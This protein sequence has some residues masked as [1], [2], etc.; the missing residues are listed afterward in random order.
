MTMDHA[1]GRLIVWFS[2][3]VGLLFELMPVPDIVLPFRPDWLLLILIYW[4]MA[5]PHRY[6]I[7]TAF[8]MGTLLDVLLGAHLGIRSLAYSLAI[9]LI[10][11]NFQRLRTYSFLQQTVL[12]GIV[13]CIYHLIVFWLQFLLEHATFSAELL[14][15]TVSSMILWRWVFW[16]L[17]RIR[18]RYKVR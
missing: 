9:Y 5:L 4:S 11:L 6:N 15:P 17:R 7:L 18:R 14:W 3:L 12:V 10:V 2:L 16:V 8:V 13:L 1:H